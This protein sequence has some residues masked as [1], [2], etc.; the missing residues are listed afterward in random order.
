[1]ESLKIRKKQTV[2]AFGA[3]LARW[4]DC[5]DCGNK[6]TCEFAPMWYGYA[7]RCEKC[8][9]KINK[10][11]K[12]EEIANIGIRTHR[13]AVAFYKGPKGELLASDGKGHMFSPDETIYDMKKDPRGWRATGKKIREKDRHGNPNI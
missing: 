5:P 12:K 1:M 13:E 11:N 6:L 3:S 2:N 8:Q 10:R 4:K 7:P 9:E